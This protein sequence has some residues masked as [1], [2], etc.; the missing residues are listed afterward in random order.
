M[1]ELR[2]PASVEA[3]A[4]VLGAMTAFPEE[5]VKSM[6]ATLTED[7]FYVA[8]HRKVFA[9]VKDCAE[10]GEPVNF[11]TVSERAK[12][13]AS[14]VSGLCDGIPRLVDVPHHAK[15]LREKAAWRQLMR[16]GARLAD[17][18]EDWELADALEEMGRTSKRLAEAAA[19]DVGVESTGDVLLS[20][21]EEL[22]RIH[23]SKGALSGLPTGL[24]SLDRMTRGIQRKE[25]TLLAAGTS[26]GKSAL[27][28]QFA[29]RA[30]REGFRVAYFSAEMSNL[31][32]GIRALSM[33]A[34]ID[35]SKMR[36]GQL[37]DF[38]WHRLVDAFETDKGL[39]IWWSDKPGRMEDV[40]RSSRTLASTGRLDMII[41][42]HLHLMRLRAR[43]ENREKEMARIASM[44][45]DLA[46]ELNVAAL[47]L[48]QFNREGAKG[49]E[50]TMSDIKDSSALE[51]AARVVLLLDRADAEGKREAQG[52]L[53]IAKNTNGPVGSVP[54]WWRP[55]ITTFQEREERA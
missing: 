49:K 47:G 24:P 31:S 28:L 48:C 55:T 20:A 4:V 53:R 27:A 29:M 45:R 22:Q 10:A 7:D 3:E 34:S 1:S 6:L 33:N 51:Q 16:F 32:L 30:A 44:L 9:A 36:S 52:T 13:E 42:D 25:V 39:P 50:P 8:E 14:F 26:K 21:V 40:E 12:L 43:T 46:V 41:V 15:Q 2:I 23:D 18:P 19:M 5:F 35:G 38:E 37:N 11:L 17:G 54:L